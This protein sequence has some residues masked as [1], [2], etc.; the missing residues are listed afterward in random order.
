MASNKKTP[1][2][3]KNRAKFNNPVVAAF[4]LVFVVI[5]S[6]YILRSFAGGIPVYRT[7]PEYWRPRIA[8]CESGSGPNSTPNYQAVN[9]SNHT[10]AYQYDTGTWRG[11]VGPDLALVYPRAIDAPPEIQDKAFYNTFARRGTQPWDAS[12]RCWGPG[13]E[14]PAEVTP[15][16]PTPPPPPA[17]AT[18]TT[19]S[20]RVLVDNKPLKDAK[21]EFCMQNGFYTTT[22]ADGRF[23]SEIP[24][25]TDYCVRVTSGVPAGYTV[26]QSNNN[27]EHASSQS[28]E[29]QKAGQNLYHGFWQLF[30]A[31]FSWDRDKDSGFVFW[32]AKQ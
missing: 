16:P 9:A 14:P 20:G 17:T 30:T 12:Y 5:G 32:Y 22:N 31:Q 25:G 21:V 24:I 7:N 4:M 28:Y 6:V 15:A 11:A 8:G 18:N 27:P 13:S 23:D 26:A 19:V 2:L 3:I 29:Y 1:N 10:G